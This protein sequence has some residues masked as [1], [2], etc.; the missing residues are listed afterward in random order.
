VATGVVWGCLAP[1]PPI[2]VPGVGGGEQAEGAST[3][4]AM[5]ELARRLDRARVDTVVLVTPHGPVFRDA[6]TLQDANRLEGSLASFGAPDVAVSAPVDRPLLRAITDQCRSRGVETN[7]LPLPSLDHGSL[8]PLHFLFGG[9]PLPLVV[10]A[11]AFLPLTVLH[12]FGHAVHEAGLSLGRRLA[13]VASGDLSHRLTA[14]APAGYDPAGKKFDDLLVESLRRGEVDRIVAFD[15]RLSDRA[16]ECGLRPLVMTL[17]GFPRS[18]LD[19]EVLSYEAPFGVGY[20]VVSLAPPAGG[21]G[22][23]ELARRAIRARVER[24][25]P[26]E[27]PGDEELDAALRR[28]AGTFVS[29]KRQ[30]QLRGCIGTVEPTCDTAAEEVL[31]NAVRAATSDYR[32]PPV[33]AEELDELDVSVD[34]LGPPEQVR[35]PNDLDPRRYGV[36][37][38]CGSRTGVL[39]PDL[40]GVDTAEEQVAIACRKAG[41]HPGQPDLQLYRFTVTRYRDDD[42]GG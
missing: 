2:I 37:V 7:L 9:R 40:P 25:G 26:P 23:V 21:I 30:G 22:P 17:G 3:R 27:V 31:H 6:V 16:G 24:G 20:A 32:F 42:G 5:E 19:T 10:A 35:D 38:R 28:P 14:D 1:H 4:Q 18:P 8:V 13:L 36:I 41:L 34:V 39:L 29:L 15:S 33:R 11:A 12:R